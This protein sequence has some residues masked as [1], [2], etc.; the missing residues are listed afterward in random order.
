MKL[1][2][3]GKR[4]E[5][6]KGYARPGASMFQDKT[7]WSLSPQGRWP[8][9]L[10]HDG[11]PDVVAAFPSQAGAGGP[12]SGKSLRNEN[13]SVARGRFE[14]LPGG[15]AP[16]YHADS[17][18]A[19]RFFYCAKASRAERAGSKHP[20]VKPVALMR[21]LA[22]LITPPGGTILD[23]FAGTGTTAEAALAEGFNA[24]LIE[25]E[26]K[27]RADI[28]RRLTVINNQ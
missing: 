4:A 5:V 18:S 21:W 20:T 12:A 2:A 25:R 24:V 10:C 27:Y 22:R 17:G 28:A 14:G 8:A 13:F 11:A 26:P 23:P 1:R 9:N 19:A 16:A 15:I 6:N 7:D 3:G